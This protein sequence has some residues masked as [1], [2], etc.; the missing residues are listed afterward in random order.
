PGVR[1]VRQDPGGLV[2]ADEPAGGGG[3]GHGGVVVLLA[4]ADRVAV[5]AAQKPRAAGGVLAAGGRGS[6]RQASAGVGDGVRAGVAVAATGGAGGRDAARAAGAAEGSSDEMGSG[7]HGTS[8][9]GGCVGA[10]G[11]GGSVGTT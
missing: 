3:H 6:N 7:A 10:G 4:L 11:D 9:A 8:L 2:S 1:P 5:Q